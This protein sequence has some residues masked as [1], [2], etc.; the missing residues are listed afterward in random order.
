MIAGALGRRYAKALFALALSERSEEPTEQALRTLV[1]AYRSSPLPSL[2]TNPAL[3]L[4]KRQAVLAEIARAAG[5]SPLLAR[6]LHLLLERRRFELLASI[7][8]HYRRLLNDHRGRVDVQVTSADGLDAGAEEN[9]KAALS[10]LSG[11]EILLHTKSDPELLGGLVVEIE[12][13][14]YDGSVRTQLR[15]LRERI[16]RGP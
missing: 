8:S 4:D 14:T 5:A 15:R 11:K 10:R 6:F 16:A 13:K 7:A 1:E 12:G 3:P 9:L 2:L